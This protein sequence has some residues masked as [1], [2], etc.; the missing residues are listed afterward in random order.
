MC[1][2]LFIKLNENLALHKPILILFFPVLITWNLSQ[3]FQQISCKVSFDSTGPALSAASRQKITFWLKGASFFSWSC[4]AYVADRLLAS[5]CLFFGF[6]SSLY[7][8]D[9]SSAP[10]HSIVQPSMHLLHHPGH[11]AGA[12]RQPQHSVPH[13]QMAGQERPDGS[14]S[15]AAAVERRGGE[16]ER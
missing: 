10:L 5:G 2:L 13:P 11:P 6:F 7:H 8:W 14:Q 9:I 3:T 15:P 1:S 16:A 4:S 12:V